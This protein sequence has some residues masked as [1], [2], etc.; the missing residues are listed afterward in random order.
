M[1]I[2]ENI[3]KYTS[4]ADQWEEAM[5]IGNGRLGGM[6]WGKTGAGSHSREIID[7]NE[8]TL[9]HGK[10]QDRNNPAAR[11]NID[12]IRKLLEEE[13]INEAEVL[14]RISMS[15]QPR[16][17]GP[18]EPLGSLLIEEH[19]R[20]E[21]TEYKRWLDLDRAEA[22]VSYS[23]DG[24]NVKR[25]YFASHIDNCIFILIEADKRV[26]DFSCNLMR[27][28]T[29]ETTFSKAQNIIGMSSSCGDRGIKFT[30]LAEGTCDGA[31][32]TCGDYLVFSDCRKAFIKIAAHSDF[33]GGNPELLCLNTLKATEKFCA[34]ELISR[35]EKEYGK[36][37]RR[38]EFD[39][40]T[41]NSDQDTDR[42]LS[43]VKN[44][45][46]DEGLIPLYFNF[47]RYLMISSSRPG[48]EAMN[49]Q[50]IWNSS[51]TPAWE[52]NYTINI[53]TQM[54]YW[55]AE[56]CN[57]SEFH[58]PLFTLIERMIPHGQETARKIYGCKGFVAHHCTNIWGDTAIE[59][60]YLPSPIWPMGGAWLA[61]HMMIHYE[62]TLDTDFLRNRAYP[63]LK[64]AAIFFRDYMVKDKDGY[65]VTGP[66]ISPENTYITSDGKTGSLC[67]GPY[68]DME[69]VTELYKSVI[70]CSEILNKDM[71]FAEALKNDLK[72][73]RPLSIN[74]KGCL[75]EWQKDYKETEPGHRHMSHL[76]ALHPG[77]EI[78]TNTPELMEACKK[79][80]KR[81]LDNGGGH[82][83]WSSAWIINFY[84]RLLDGE[85]A[86]DQ[87]Y[88][89]LRK[90]TYP[91]FLDVHPPFQID[92]NMGGTAG[93]AQ[94]L[95]QSHT[96][97][98]QLLPAL[99]H[100]WATGH[101]K[102]LKARGGFTV[103]IYWENGRLKKTDIYSAKE[104]KT[105]IIL[106]D[107]YTVL[108][109]GKTEKNIRS[110]KISMNQ[111]QTLAISFFK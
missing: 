80:L 15:S 85:K 84:A 83:G 106:P 54:N 90:S 79:T 21:I 72:H 76:F 44:G 9:W 58:E 107:I 28:P 42:R 1:S 87:I 17:F 96:G 41:D 4:P 75:M 65:L 10:Y 109:N 49:L 25:T 74:S 51:F 97:N 48:C 60:N 16:Y 92:G 13:K 46:E 37:Y 73:F 57:L 43:D 103:D 31:I 36:V 94:M 78:N 62:Y 35:H 69:I 88:N 105:R 50:G 2:T 104:N 34:E 81:R 101:I 68:M 11:A 23:I 64:E 5:P 95:L 27:R 63:V 110:I 47:G 45:A 18:Y 82:T 12:T 56:I 30:C 14:S 6:I 66:S 33:Y 102:G 89:L 98:I 20:G 7:L 19:N 70:K 86:R 24:V 93:I 53:N 38:V 77:T 111:G 91:S 67:M 22:Y 26:L 61:L 55:P 39:I 108:F 8:D 99:P 59:G 3:L 100:E 29:A 32:K 71:D 52:C 40:S